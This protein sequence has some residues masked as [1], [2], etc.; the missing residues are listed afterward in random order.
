M[1]NADKKLGKSPGRTGD[2]VSG[3]DAGITKL[4]W[5]IKSKYTAPEMEPLLTCHRILVIYK[6]REQMAKNSICS[7]AIIIEDRFTEKISH[8]QL[9]SNKVVFLCAAQLS[10]GGSAFYPTISPNF[11]GESHLSFPFISFIILPTLFSSPNFPGEYRVLS[12]LCISSDGTT[13]STF[14]ILPSLPGEK[15]P[16]VYNPFFDN[17]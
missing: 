12:P 17:S 7:Q 4:L 13:L 5:H 2:H 15:I 3:Q 8:R 1:D 10:A 6:S 16:S 9:H 14:C 11:P